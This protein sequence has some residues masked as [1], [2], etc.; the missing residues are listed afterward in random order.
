MIKPRQDMF[1]WEK[2]YEYEYRNETGKLGVRVSEAL[3]SMEQVAS[4]ESLDY[5]NVK[6]VIDKCNRKARQLVPPEMYEETHA[7]FLQAISSYAKGMEILEPAAKE[8]D[9]K[10]MMKAG[11]L[12]NEGNS[13][14][15]ITKSRIWEA[16]EERIEKNNRNKN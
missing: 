4:S 8:K 6:A 15:Q 11:R 14:I 13:F 9:A 5:S 10:A 7:F 1:P 2:P 12:I 16:V 3:K